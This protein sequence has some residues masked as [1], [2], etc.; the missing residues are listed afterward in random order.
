MPT[1]RR[2]PDWGNRPDAAKSDQG[3]AANSGEQIPSGSSRPNSGVVAI[4]GLWE[5]G[6]GAICSNTPTSRHV[7]STPIRCRPVQIGEAGGA[8]EKRSILDAWANSCAGRCSP[9]DP[10]PPPRLSNPP[11]WS[12]SPPGGRQPP[13]SP[14]PFRWA[15][16][17][18]T[19]IKQGNQAP[20]RL[21]LDHQLRKRSDPI[22][23]DL[24][25]EPWIRGTDRPGRRRQRRR[26]TLH[27]LVGIMTGRSRGSNRV[28]LANVAAS[29]ACAGSRVFAN[30][31]N[32]S[33]PGICFS[34][35]TVRRAI[36]STSGC[37]SSSPF[38]TSP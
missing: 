27:P 10:Q 20:K 31:P 2:I 29:R 38:H 36:T 12:S 7:F 35:Q 28:I 33:S 13:S 9:A 16:H 3:A 22:V 5:K 8:V 30:S 25:P 32:A 23:P 11:T 34:S 15:P 18:L 17:Y 24:R 26:S 21:A 14:Q 4:P 1:R 19:H 37:E 6:R